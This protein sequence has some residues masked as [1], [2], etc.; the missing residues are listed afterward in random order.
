MTG[1]DLTRP[2]ARALSGAR[3][4]PKSGGQAAVAPEQLSDAPLPDRR[5]G[6]VP[7]NSL[8]RCLDERHPER[9]T[10]LDLEMVTE[11]EAGDL[12]QRVVTIPDQRMIFGPTVE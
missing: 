8:G 11:Q 4:V 12:L 2:T 10:A 1:A 9:P 5:S 7:P 6:W 3:D